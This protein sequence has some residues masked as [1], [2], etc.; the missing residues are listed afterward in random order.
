MALAL[1]VW[2]V[3]TPWVPTVPKFKAVALT[4]HAASIDALTGKLVDA[5]AADTGCVSRQVAAAKSGKI[6]LPMRCM[7]FA[8]SKCF[9]GKRTVNPVEIW[10]F[11]KIKNKWNLRDQI[12]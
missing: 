12:I 8:R 9:Y 1:S 3:A 11:Y 7:R 6:G 10:K 2:E 5:V 4:V